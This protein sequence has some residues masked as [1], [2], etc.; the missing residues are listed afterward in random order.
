MKENNVSPL[1]RK[2]RKP[3]ITDSNHKLKLSPNLLVQKFDCKTPIIVWL[4]DITCNDSD[5]GWLYE[6][7]FKD[8]ATREVVGWAMEDHMR[9]ELCCDAL[10]MA[11]GRRGPV[12]G[13]INHSDRGSQ[14]A[15]GDYRKLT[16][17]ASIT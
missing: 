8:M 3:A 2:C 17:K 12:T 13:L 15:G 16:K 4:A 10:T 7:G 11:V 1:L 14:Y 9:A 6:A 5:E